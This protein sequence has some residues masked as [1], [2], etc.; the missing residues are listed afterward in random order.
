MKFWGEIFKKYHVF[1]LLLIITFGVIRLCY[2]FSLRD[3]HHVD[4]TWSY[5]FANSYYD[6]YIYSE[7][8]YGDVADPGT[9]K[10]IN[11]WLPGMM[12]KDYITVQDGERFAFDSVLYNKEYDLGPALFPLILH[13]IC[14]LFPGTFSWCYAFSIN[15]ICF[16][17][18]LIL[19]YLIVYEIS[20]SVYVGLFSSFFY[21]LS[22]CGTG[23]YLYLR[24]YALFT[25]FVLALFYTMVR[26]IKKK[27][28]LRDYL[29]LI[30]ISI[31]GCMTHYYFLVIAFFLTFFSVL[32]IFI[33]KRFFDGVKFGFTMLIS[34][35]AFF[36]I[37]RPA[38]KMLFPYFTQET[39]VGGSNG[40]AASYKWNISAANM[41][42]FQG[43]IGFFVDFCIPLFLAI[44]G[45]ICFIAI[46]LGL[47]VFLFRNEKWFKKSVVVFKTASVSFGHILF[48]FFKKNG[49]ILWIPAVAS[50]AYFF[51]I[52]HSVSLSSMGYIE[53]YLFAAMSLFLI[54]Y[55]SIIGS[56][57]L[58]IICSKL[59]RIIKYSI[60]CILF[61]GMLVLSVRSNL[62]ID[63]F[64]F[65]GMGE[66]E[67][68]E[69]LDGKQCYVMIHAVRDMVWLS[70][71]LSNTEDVYI[72]MALY[73]PLEEHTI[74]DLDSN[75][76]ILL[77]LTDFLTEEQKVSY[78]ESGDIELVGM[79][80]PSVYMTADDYID[81]VEEHNG[82]S[83]SSVNEFST[84]IGDLRLYKVS[85]DTYSD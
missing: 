71:V 35:V 83:Y 63:E 18:S 66:D 1:V 17:G 51:I 70:P 61:I 58:S 32:V 14:S 69:L 6:P 33:K 60:A 39:S 4:E 52:P 37:Y 84:F 38:L 73:I 13:F 16:I 79:N 12:F 9:W 20:G 65:T 29:F 56:A 19:F 82:L 81:M 72:D 62:F 44:F 55:L 27:H 36:V 22:G 57:F 78:E 34:V 53:R 47:I 50:I 59:K 67:L 21:V 31:L 8:R 45:V 26:F 48:S 15:L 46:T 68:T 28:K 74:P 42:F 64:K 11:S 23:N 10:N 30:I 43:T 41:H 3:G 7:S 49:I 24:V 75:S 2:I 40:Y 76:L 54:T 85:E 5:G 80:R 25:F 77:N